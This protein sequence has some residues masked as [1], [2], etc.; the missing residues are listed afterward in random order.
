MRARN[1]FNEI[2]NTFN[3]LQH[4]LLPGKRQVAARM[5]AQNI[6]DALVHCVHVTLHVSVV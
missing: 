6:F 2:M 4:M 3:V 1:V 5:R